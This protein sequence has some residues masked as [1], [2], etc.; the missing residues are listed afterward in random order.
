MNLIQSRPD[1]PPL[2][3]RRFRLGLLLVLISPLL[4]A[5]GGT[6]P[7][8]RASQIDEKP[9]KVVELIES[10]QTRSIPTLATTV[11]EFLQRL[12]VDVGSND[13]VTPSL[14][15]QLEGN[16]PVVVINKSRPV[17]IIDGSQR[18]VIHSALVEPRAIVEGAGYELDDEDK[19]VWLD[20]VDEAD[21]IVLLPTIH[22]VHPTTY[23]L[24]IGLRRVDLTAS[25][26]TVATILAEN[27]IEFGP[28]YQVYPELNTNLESGAVITL[29]EKPDFIDVIAD[30]Y[31]LKQINEGVYS[32]PAGQRTVIDP[33]RP[34][35]VE[36][37]Y[38]VSVV[39]GHE[40]KR[41]VITRRI[42]DPGQPRREQ[43]GITRSWS[44]VTPIPKSERALLMTSVGIDESDWEYVSYI[45]ERESNWRPG[46]ANPSSGA[47]GLCQSLP[48]NKM[49]SAGSDWRTN[50]VTQLR[51]CHDYAQRRYK[52]WDN[53]YDFWL[54]NHWW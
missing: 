21:T 32:L 22:I 50:P 8:G 39:A 37:V 48:A 40:V 20:S 9:M 10:N 7:A 18:R 17:R 49:A 42:I 19:V 2:S 41:E 23:T 31:D 5:L 24:A 29:V 1:E 33:G 45:I 47:Y 36:I 44:P 25:A 4:L 16:N 30:S 13:L 53:A 34:R 12:G 35:Q 3:R 43:Y 46:V 14:D 52:G 6:D 51:W 11:G 27:S 54:R 15:S 38:R 26:T 28:N